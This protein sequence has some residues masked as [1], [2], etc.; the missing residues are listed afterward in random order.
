MVRG[1]VANEE[2]KSEEIEA[3]IYPSDDLLNRLFIA[4]NVAAGDKKV[5][6]AIKLIVDKI[7]KGLQPYARVSKIT[8]LDKALEMTTTRKIKRGAVAKP[9]APKAKTPAKKAA[10]PA[11]KPAP[12]KKPAAKPAAKKAPAK[13]AAEKKAPAKKPAAKKVAEK[14]TP[15]KKT[16]AAKKPASKPKA[17][18]AVKKAPAKKPAAKKR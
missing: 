18:P 6:D 17:K 1:Y 7:N 12:V 15:A 14:K 2:T 10:A 16:A 5:Y 4:R 3:L 9:A 8:I 11:K 13:K